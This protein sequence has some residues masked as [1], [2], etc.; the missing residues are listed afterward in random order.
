MSRATL[1]VLGAGLAALAVAAGAFGAHALAPRITPERLQTF[2]TAV[3]YQMFHA[4]GLLV[5]AML[6]AG[7]REATWAGILFVAGVVLFSG[8]LYLLVLTGVRVFGAITPLGGVALIAAWVLL[9]IAG[10][11][12]LAR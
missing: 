4:L 8:S 1:F 6:D 3:R 10:A 5:L 7:T 11:R 12:A 9:A 2:E